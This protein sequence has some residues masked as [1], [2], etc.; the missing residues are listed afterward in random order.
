MFQRVKTIKMTGSRN[1]HEAAQD[2]LSNNKHNCIILF[3]HPF[4]RGIS[5]Q[6]LIGTSLGFAAKGLSISHLTTAGGILID[7]ASPKFPTG[8]GDSR[9]SSSGR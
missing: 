6:G 1:P 9:M 7:M 8:V 2:F 5:A 4:T 3:S